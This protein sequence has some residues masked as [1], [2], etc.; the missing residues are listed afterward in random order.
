MVKSLDIPG[1]RCRTEKRRKF[2]RFQNRLNFKGIYGKMDR[3][4][5]RNLR[6]G[7]DGY[8]TRCDNLYKQASKQ[9]SKHNCAYF[10]KSRKFKLKPSEGYDLSYLLGGFLF[11]TYIKFGGA[12]I[13]L[14]HIDTEK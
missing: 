7:L 13:E 10:P 2:E 11:L 8:G 6:K 1:S 14:A 9:A 5:K 12:V 4:K 3:T